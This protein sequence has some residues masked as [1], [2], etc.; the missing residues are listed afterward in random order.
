MKKPREEIQILE[1]LEALATSPGFAHAVAQLCFRDSVIHIQDALKP[2]EMDRLFTGERLIRAELTTVIGLMAKKP[3][4]VAQQRPEVIQSY[5][6]R[7][8]ALMSELHNAISYPMFLALFDEARSGDDAPNPWHGPGMREPIFYGAESA[9]A[10][11]YRDLVPEKYGADDVWLLKNKG[12][13]SGQ[14]RTVAMTMCCLIDQKVS[15]M[16]M[17]P[18]Q[19]PVAQQPVNDLLTVRPDLQRLGVEPL[20]VTCKK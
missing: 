6:K 14:A 10:F 8:D 13:T 18:L 7:T 9:Y 15:R 12:F 3:L 19:N 2:A 1:E 16:L 11:Q 17:E 5:V 4:D 20:A